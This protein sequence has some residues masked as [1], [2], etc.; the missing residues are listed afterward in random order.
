[1]TETSEAESE[2]TEM[3]LNEN[4]INAINVRRWVR[5]WPRF[6]AEIGSGPG[7]MLR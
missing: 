4:Y 3:C 2:A 6:D 5:Q 7:S 1:M